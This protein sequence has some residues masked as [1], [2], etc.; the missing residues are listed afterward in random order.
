MKYAFQDLCDGNLSLAYN[1]LVAGLDYASFAYVLRCRESELTYE[2]KSALSDFHFRAVHRLP[3]T[4]PVQ[5]RL[6]RL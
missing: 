3:A 5:F 4:A 6:E 2:E 1:A